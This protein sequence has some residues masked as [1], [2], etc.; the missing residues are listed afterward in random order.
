VTRLEQLVPGARVQGLTPTSAV[1]VVQV[2]WHGE[3][4]LTLTY[5]DAKG[6]V[7]DLL[8]YRDDEARLV[9]E[10]PGVAFLI[11]EKCN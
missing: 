9:I 7:D 10:A 4:A 6:R 3:G 5:K 8:V 2:Q 11:G 1:T